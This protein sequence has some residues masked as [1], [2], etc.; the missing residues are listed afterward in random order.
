MKIRTWGMLFCAAAAS[1]AVSSRAFSGDEPAGGGGAPPGM[2][3][4]DMKAM[5]AKMAECMKN[6]Q[7]G[8]NHEML[9]KFVGS[10]KTTT[11]MWMMGEGSGAP[12]VTEGTSEVK[13][14]LGKRFVREEHN[15]F[16][17]MPDPSGQ[18]SKK[19]YEGSGVLGFDNERGMYVGDWASNMSTTLLTFKGGA[20]PDGKTLTFYGE[21][22]EPMLGIY[23]RFLKYVHRVVDKDH[24][25]MELYDL[26]AGEKYK[27]FEVSYER[28]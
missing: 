17:I 15:G 18:M 14:I 28:K 27:V 22:D 20:S 24:H 2:N 13:W 6:M 3:P 5:M 26:H 11:K 12:V 1:I 7:P 8:K 25:V 16:M 23:G 10:W 9:E 21:M 4:D 19:P